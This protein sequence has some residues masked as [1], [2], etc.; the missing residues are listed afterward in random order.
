MVKTFNISPVKRIDRRG[1]R[2]LALHVWKDLT[3][4][5]CEI[6]LNFVSIREITDLNKNYLGKDKPTDVIAFN[7]GNTPATPLIADIYICP[8]LARQN[9]ELYA[10]NLETE[11]ARLV[12]HG[13]LHIAGY[14]DATEKER[15]EMRRLE[16]CFLKKYT[17]AKND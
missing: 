5:K 1:L 9:A 8:Q 7:L 13:V 11:L 3:S 6:S 2:K 12:I 14:D 17:S 10:C 16:D 15:H 4:E